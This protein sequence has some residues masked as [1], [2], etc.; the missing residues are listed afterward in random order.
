MANLKEGE[1]II[2]VSYDANLEYNT[3]GFLNNY[4]LEY[5][6]YPSKFWKSFGPIEVNLILDDKI[7][8]KQSNLGSEK[9]VN[10]KIKWTINHQNLDT[11]SIKLSEKTSLF[12]KTLLFLQ[13]LGIAVIALIVLFF[14]HLKTMKQN[15]KKYVLVLGIVVVPVLFYVIYFLSYDLIDFSL[16]KNHTKH[17]YYFLFIVTYPLLL[18]IY[19]LLTWQIYKRKIKT[20]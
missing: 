9:A 1:N 6:L 4:K 8:F 3:Y 16:G 5:S 7:E 11:I 14:I 15:P 12:S 19:W 10:H 20:N 17:G 2:E 18:L 13:P